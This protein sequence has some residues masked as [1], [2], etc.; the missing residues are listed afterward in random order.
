MHRFHRAEEA[1]LPP[2]DQFTSQLGQWPCQIKLIPVNAPYFDGEKLLI[3]ADCTAFAYANLHQEFM[4]GKIT[5]IGCPKLDSVDCSQK[6][7]QIIQTNNIQS[8]TLIRMEV[9]CCG[10]LE[11]SVSPC[12]RNNDYDMSMLCSISISDR[13]LVSFINSYIIHSS[14]FQ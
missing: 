6:L 13:C 9:P 4:K 3:A 7:T 8:V 2:V 12:N 11:A 14:T 1:V 5:L 10:G